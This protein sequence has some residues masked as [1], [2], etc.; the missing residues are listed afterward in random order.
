MTEGQLSPACRNELRTIGIDFDKPLL[1]AYP[2]GQWERA[3][4]LILG[5]LFPLLP[6]P[7]ARIELGRLFMK[8]F[9]QT[10]IGQAAVM[11]GKALGVRRTLARMTRNMRNG[12]NDTETEVLEHGPGHVE[13]V[14]RMRPEFLGQWANK[15]SP[16]GE[17]FVGVLQAAMEL[18]GARESNVTLKGYDPRIRQTHYDVR[19]RE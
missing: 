16:L 6:L 9:A 10:A 1:S 8:G 14:T 4:E 15:P 5:E 17:Q 2:L 3:T 13:L 11:L 12:N 18:L 7:A 19:W